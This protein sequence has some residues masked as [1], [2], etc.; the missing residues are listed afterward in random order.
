MMHGTINI[1]NVGQLCIPSIM[2]TAQRKVIHCQPN[3]IPE[4]Y[5]LKEEG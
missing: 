4:M 2:R 5:E 3:K 1:K